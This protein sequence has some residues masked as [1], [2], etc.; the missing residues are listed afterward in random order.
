MRC[1][2]TGHF[3]SQ[4][5]TVVSALFV[6]C[7]GLFLSIDPVDYNGKSRKIP[8]VCDHILSMR[9]EESTRWNKRKKEEKRNTRDK[10]SSLTYRTARS[11]FQR[12]GQ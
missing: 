11:P 4:R 12:T 10:P 7:L 1:G 2:R 9:R 8:G 5:W 6:T 3:F